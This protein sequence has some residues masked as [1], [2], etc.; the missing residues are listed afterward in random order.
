MHKYV[1][2]LQSAPADRFARTNR[3]LLA[4]KTGDKEKKKK[5]VLSQSI[6]TLGLALELK[7]TS[8]NPNRRTGRYLTCGG[9]CALCRILAGWLAREN[10]R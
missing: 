4:A 9:S 3:G 10:G 7:N 1:L 5:I 6:R 8:S 2:E